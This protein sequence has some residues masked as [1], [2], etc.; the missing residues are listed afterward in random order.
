MPA[1]TLAGKRLVLVLGKGG[2]GRTSITAAL[3]QAAASA[4]LETLIAEVS[5]Q[6]RLLDLFG[7]GD[8]GHD[9]RERT[10]A[11]RLH[12]ISIDPA[13]ALEE[14][15]V[16][17]LPFKALGRRLAGDH[18]FSQLAAAA[19]GLRELVTI[20]KLWYL[21]QDSSERE[22]PYEIV[23]ADLPAT[24]HGL[25]MLRAPSTFSDIASSGPLHRQTARVAHDLAQPAHT[26]AIVVTLAQEL[27]VNEA[28]MLTAGL[29]SLRVEPAFAVANAVP[30]PLVAEQDV[31]ALE[32]LARDAPGE[33]A[34]TAAQVGAE[35]GRADHERASEIARLEREASIDV[36]TLPFSHAVGGD[37]V[38]ELAEHFERGV[39]R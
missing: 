4:G 28:I 29:R 19:P 25:A 17:H 31:P 26:G 2:V 9:G 30:D 37:V 33:L 7:H 27:P 13:R 15:F 5:G 6:A 35:R 11:P 18:A 8:A 34:R 14:Y 1:V 32:Q 36:R 10:L 3:G 24:G 20:G 21:A 12:G 39:W 23:I 38:G 16:L 22:A